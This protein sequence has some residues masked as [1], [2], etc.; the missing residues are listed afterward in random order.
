MKIGLGEDLPFAMAGLRDGERFT[1]VT[2]APTPDL[3]A[4]HDRMPVILTPDSEAAWLAGA[5][6]AEVLR[7][8]EGR[9]VARDD[10][11]PPRES[12]PPPSPRQGDLF[13]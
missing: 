3:A 6:P 12:P 7:P 4:I 11:D 10:P 2:C 5:D 8:Y 1:I 9:L 13:G